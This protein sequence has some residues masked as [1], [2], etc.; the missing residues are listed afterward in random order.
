MCASVQNVLGKG[1]D[2]RRTLL[3]D[4]ERSP[5]FLGWYSRSSCRNLELLHTVLPSNVRNY[6]GSLVSAPITDLSSPGRSLTC[7]L[8]SWN[9]VTCKLVSSYVLAQAVLGGGFVSMN[10]VFFS[11]LRPSIWINGK[12]QLLGFRE[13]PPSWTLPPNFCGIPLIQI[14]GRYRKRSSL[15][16][17]K[18]PNFLSLVQIDGRH[19]K[20]NLPFSFLSY[21]AQKS[22]LITQ[23]WFFLFLFFLTW[24]SHR[25]YVWVVTAW[26]FLSAAL[27]D[28]LRRHVTV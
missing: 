22:P 17:P 3:P 14:D 27:N 10:S 24:R 16:Q 5:T 6:Q 2:C 1:Q 23:L 7:K 28:R 9:L 26:T 25:T 12:P 4:W 21:T 20:R 11:L 15:W 8:V 13:F 19:R 18:S